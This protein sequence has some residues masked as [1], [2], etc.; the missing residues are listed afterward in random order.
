[1]RVGFVLSDC[2]CGGGLTIALYFLEISSCSFCRLALI[3]SVIFSVRL[4]F[5]FV[6]TI[7]R[8][9]KGLFVVLASICEFWNG[10]FS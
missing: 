8:M 9:L 6:D 4:S 1:V 10:S 7:Y 2:I 5:I 3:V